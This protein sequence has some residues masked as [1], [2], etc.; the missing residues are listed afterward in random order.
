[1]CRWSWW[2]T[3]SAVGSSPPE[4]VNTAAAS[5]HTTPWARARAVGKHTMPFFSLCVAMPQETPT[6]PS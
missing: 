2:P 5:L 6:T 3:P 1:M 4:I